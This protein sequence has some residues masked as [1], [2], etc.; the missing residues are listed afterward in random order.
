MTAANPKVMVKMRELVAQ[1]EATMGNEDRREGAA[2]G[3]D[4]GEFEAN[5]VAE[6]MMTTAGVRP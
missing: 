4:A 3:H 2:T 1:A 5:G 6:I